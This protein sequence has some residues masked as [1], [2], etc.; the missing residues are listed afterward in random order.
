VEKSALVGLKSLLSN[1]V[2]GHVRVWRP[3]NRNILWAQL[4]L[5]EE[6]LRRLLTI[7]LLMRPLTIHWLRS[8]FVVLNGSCLASLLRSLS[9]LGVIFRDLKL[10]FWRGFLTGIYTCSAGETLKVL[11]F[12]SFISTWHVENCQMQRD[13]KRLEW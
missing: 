6:V 8:V 4:R 2:D 7:R 12:L 5:V 9:S 10:K 3:R 11:N 1:P 13:G